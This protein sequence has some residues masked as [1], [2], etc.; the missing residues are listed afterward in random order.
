M[1]KRIVIRRACVMLVIGL[2]CY[3][4]AALTMRNIMKKSVAYMSIPLLSFFHIRTDILS[5][6]FPY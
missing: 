3:G 2:R 1:N 6:V 5:Y 4:I